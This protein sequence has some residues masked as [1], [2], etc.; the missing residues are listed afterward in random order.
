MGEVHWQDQLKCD[1]L[2]DAVCTDG[3]R[4]PLKGGS[5]GGREI[6]AGACSHAWQPRP[7]A[8]LVM[9]GCKVA[10][11][12][13]RLCQAMAAAVRG[14][15]CGCAR[16][17]LRLSPSQRRACDARLQARQAMAAAVRS[18][19]LRLCDGRCCAM[20]AAVRSRWLRLCQVMD[21]AVRPR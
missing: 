1:A 20:A 6:A 19:W 18:R 17:C 21:A 11:R 10:R 7:N 2:R 4:V 13:L 15:G 12:W 16:Q 3:A 8:G 9:Q 5:N 14:D